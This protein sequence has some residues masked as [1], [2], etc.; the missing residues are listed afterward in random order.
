MT[1]WSRQTDRH[2]QDDIV[3]LYTL[4]VSLQT[5]FPTLV[6]SLAYL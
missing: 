1:K 6:P 3:N 5:S 2:W 4:F